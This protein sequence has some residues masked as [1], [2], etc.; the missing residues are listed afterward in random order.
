VRRAVGAPDLAE[1]LQREGIDPLGRGSEEFA[2]L[3]ARE[4]AQWRELAKSASIKL[5]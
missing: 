4:I 5:D 1:R 3:I 2:A